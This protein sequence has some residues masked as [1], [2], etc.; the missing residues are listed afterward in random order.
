MSPR[1]EIRSTYT[2]MVRDSAGPRST[3]SE[4]EAERVLPPRDRAASSR[5]RTFDVS[6]SRGPAE[7]SLLDVVVAFWDGAFRMDAVEIGVSAEGSSAQEA[8]GRLVEEVS[9]RLRNSADERAA[10]LRDYPTD[11]WFRFVPPAQTVAAHKSALADGVADALQPFYEFRGDSV[12]D[13]LAEN[14]S[15]TGLLFETRKVIREYFGPEVKPALEV[16]ADPEAL[17]DHQLFVLI[18]TELPRKEART[19]LAELD[20]EWWLAV[21]PASEGKMEIALD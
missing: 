10:L 17:G 4:R 5:L 1:T 8:Y 21:L 20:R 11:M 19:R 15:L 3:D 12:R 2:R 13:F 6:L 18:R 7:E 14:P 9:A 16:V